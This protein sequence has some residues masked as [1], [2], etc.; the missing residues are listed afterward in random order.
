MY[1]RSRVIAN[2]ST[3]MSESVSKPPA[4]IIEP[5]KSVPEIAMKSN[6]PGD[7]ETSAHS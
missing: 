3:N 2:P 6:A 4:S 1:L 7:H 5:D